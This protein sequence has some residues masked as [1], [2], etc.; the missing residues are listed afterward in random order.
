MSCIYYYCT[1]LQL[2]K[3]NRLL[4]PGVKITVENK[5]YYDVNQIVTN[6]ELGHQS[7]ASRLRDGECV[8]ECPEEQREGV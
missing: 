4:C 5:T 2:I 6:D 7:G 1:R 8:V 3:C